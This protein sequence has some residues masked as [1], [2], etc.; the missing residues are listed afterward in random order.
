MNDRKTRTSESPEKLERK[1][2]TLEEVSFVFIICF[3][4]LT[5]LLQ[6]NAR[7]LKGLSDQAKEMEELREENRFLKLPSAARK[8]ERE[9]Q[10]RSRRQ[11]ISDLKN[12]LRK[13][14]LFN[15]GYYK[16]IIHTFQPLKVA[17]D[18]FRWDH[19]LPRVRLQHLPRRREYPT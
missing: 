16:V 14:M 9:R 7:L 13:C 3:L 19:L 4:Y 17:G 1:I 6:E 8:R 18:L 5:V 11:Q 10:H 12:D 2:K 15:L